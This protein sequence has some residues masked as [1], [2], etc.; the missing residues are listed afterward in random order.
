MQA[1]KRIALMLRNVSEDQSAN[2]AW[3][4]VEFFAGFNFGLCT[5][6]KGH[7]LK[8]VAF[9]LLSCTVSAF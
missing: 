8:S 3:T 2:I 9:S 1:F 4:E 7:T 5:T 6:E